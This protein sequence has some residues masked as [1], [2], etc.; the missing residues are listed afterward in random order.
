[1]NVI[2]RPEI[3]I[4]SILNVKVYFPESGETELAYKVYKG[5]LRIGHI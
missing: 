1:M 2:E 5:I 3:L 4:P